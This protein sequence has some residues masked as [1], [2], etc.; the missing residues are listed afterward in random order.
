M[1]DMTFI[2]TLR[3]LFYAN[4]LNMGNKHFHEKEPHYLLKFS[5]RKLVLKYKSLM[6]NILWKV[7]K[8]MI[9][10]VIQTA[11]KG[12]TTAISVKEG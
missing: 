12:K 7:L 2:I 10:F 8:K 9:A 5:L 11:I 4:T 6:F 1:E 3:D